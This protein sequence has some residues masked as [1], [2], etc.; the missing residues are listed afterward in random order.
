MGGVI[1]VAIRPGVAVGIRSGTA[2]ASQPG[3]PARLRP[4]PGLLGGAYLPLRRDHVAV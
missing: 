3:D 4:R 2:V 1:N